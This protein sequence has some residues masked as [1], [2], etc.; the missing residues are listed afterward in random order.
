MLPAI[1]R[2]LHDDASRL[3]VAD[4]A[5]ACGFYDA[6]MRQWGNG[7]TVSAEPPN[8]AGSGIDSSP[9]PVPTRIW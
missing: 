7:T 2:M 1:A 3:R 6:H 5:V 8:C 4:V 9:S